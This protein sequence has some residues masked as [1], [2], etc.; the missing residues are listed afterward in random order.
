MASPDFDTSSKGCACNAQAAQVIAITIQ[1]DFITFFMSFLPIFNVRCRLI[2]NRD[3]L[4]SWLCAPSADCSGTA[5]VMNSC[6]NMCQLPEAIWSSMLQSGGGVVGQLCAISSCAGSMSA[7][8]S[9]PVPLLRV[10][11]EIMTNVLCIESIYLYA[12]GHLEPRICVCRPFGNESSTR[13]MPALLLACMQ[14]NNK[15]M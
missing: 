15:A 14:A 3:A 5:A 6:G 10:K 1:D 4:S 11:T 13:A 9:T 12:I 8:S 7:S 2:R